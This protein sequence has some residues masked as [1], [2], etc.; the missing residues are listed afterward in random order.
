MHA[1]LGA[2]FRTKGLAEVAALDCRALEMDWQAMLKWVKE[3]K[4]DIVFVGELL[5]STCGAA[6][7]WYFNEG[8]R[9]IKEALPKT[10]AVAGGLWYSGDYERQMRLN[11]WI[12]YIMI[13]EAEL[14]MEDLIINL[15][16]KKKSD[17]DIPGLVSRQDNDTIVIGPHRDLI[18]DLNVLPMPAYDLFPMDKY[19]GHTYWKPFAELM[20]SR[21]CPGKCHFC[22]EWALYDSRTAIQDFTSW[23]GLKG[24]R[25]VDELDIL[26]KQYGITTIVFQDDAFNTDTKAMIEF[27]EEKLKRGNKIDWVCLGRADQWISQHD[28]LPLM[29]KAGL[30]LALTGVEVEDDMTLAK[31]GKG[32]TID[33]IKKTV[34][35]LRENNIGSVGTVLIGLKED[36]EAKIKQRLHIADEID[37]DI[38]ALDYLTPVPNSPDWRYG[39]KKGW[40]DPD[41]INLKDWDFQHPVVPTDHLTIE[42]VGR[43]GAWCM[44][45]YYSKPERIHRIFTSD[46]D[47]KVKLC[48]KDFMSNIAK[49]EANSRVTAGTGSTR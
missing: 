48:V 18:P 32:V 42:E 2:Y 26:E 30:F 35:I 40:F 49:W 47:Q 4:P 37:P 21:G 12:D 31:Q 24:K 13:G 10:I 20:T 5:H 19:V 45:E 33:Q 27:C 9:L 1:Q 34:R 43:L 3:Y 15:K 25:I 14:T 36:T 22:Y 41:K 44:R 38:F 11:P 39:I 7:I 23:R 16:D 8:L 28:I 17:R 6:V 29:K 46:Y